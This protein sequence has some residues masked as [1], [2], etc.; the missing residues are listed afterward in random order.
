MAYR[1]KDLGKLCES[2]KV[3]INKLILLNWI[4]DLKDC[5]GNFCKFESF[6]LKNDTS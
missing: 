3:I 5:M 2:M 1:V 4:M 6:G